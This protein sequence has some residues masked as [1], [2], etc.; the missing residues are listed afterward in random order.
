M[1]FGWTST[2]HAHGAIPNSIPNS[3][4]DSMQDSASV[5]QVQVIAPQES[6]APG[7]ELPIAIVLNIKAGWHIWTNDRE[8]P[9]DIA[10]FDGAVLT[11]VSMRGGGGVVRPARAD[12]S[13]W[14]TDDRDD[15]FAPI[16]AQW[17]PFHAVSADVG[18]G[19]QK[20]AVF[21]GQ[22]VVFVP[23]S[24]ARD[25][26]T[27]SRTI[28]FRLELQAC[29]ATTCVAPAMIDVTIPINIAVGGVDGPPNP[30]FNSF[31]ST[32]LAEIHGGEPLPT[33]IAFDFFD[34]HFSIDPQGSGFLVL[35]VI[36]AL[37]G[38]LLNF[39]PCV[40]PV[41][42]LK[43]M[44]LARSA[45]NR[46]RCVVLGIA[47]SCGVVAFWIALGIAVALVAGFTSS[48]QLFQY[49]LFTIGV[50]A[51]IAIMAVGMC[52]FFS[53]PLP[54]SIA[55][56]DFRHDTIAGSTGFG[57]MTAVL[58][59][60]CT[61]PLMG[62]AAAWAATQSPWI[63]LVVF[64]TIGFG[65][66]LPYLFLS[67]F[68]QLV[69]HVP[70]SGPASDLVKQTMGLL[71]LAAAAYFVGAGVSG[72]MVAP[73]EPPS[74][75]YWW[76]VSVL[77]IAAGCWLFWRTLRITPR[78]RLRAGFC[79]LG[80][81]IALASAG[82]GIRLTDHGKTDWVYYTPDRLADALAG[83]EPI[84]LDFTA[85]WCLNCKTLEKAVLESHAVLER[86][87]AGGVRTIKVDLTGN[88]EP[89]RALLKAHGRVTIPLLV[90]LAP[91]GTPQG[92]EIFKSD[93]YT[94]GEVVD[95]IDRAART[96]TQGESKSVR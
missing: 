14:M 39:T 69:S 30:L 95:A 10:L 66:A 88:N 9:D 32:I 33:T 2:T 65:M 68:P 76:A 74:N 24:I 83:D 82:V 57:V 1:I 7:A 55:G 36:S 5:V 91:D 59:T 78:R 22:S 35:L 43:I 15:S 73:P 67:A 3:I 62:A 37:G 25:A 19:A 20:Y 12:G 87:D 54:Q 18:E 94:P 8:R 56:I 63:V 27:G 96:A 90:I 11:S 26:P 13:G 84:M 86:L 21:D 72:W 77:G 28:S 61:A 34:F 80:V 53:I 71:L 47:L 64:G 29:T 75:S 6:F 50:G 92:T 4:Q 16:L 70:K 48:S 81:V 41:I 23:L 49:P 52:G 60:P 46:R 42:P 58:S 79:S 85:E 89:G 93:A 17:P 45:G 51:I 40:L 38:L 44:G 31:D